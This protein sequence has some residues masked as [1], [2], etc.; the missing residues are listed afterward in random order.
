MKPREPGVQPWVVPVKSDSDIVE[1]RL[2]TR[3]LAAY[4]GFEG[5]DLAM[6]AAAVSE[7]TRN[8]VE[9]ASAGEVVLRAVRR[10]SKRG[11]EVVARDRGP[12]IPD[13]GKAMEDGF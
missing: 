1:A 12:G 11:L 7:I 6:I 13:V 10:G 5:S 9:H 8:I 3:T 4:I 2:A